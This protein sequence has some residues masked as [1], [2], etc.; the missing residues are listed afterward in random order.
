[1]PLIVFEGIDGSGKTHQAKRL[2]ETLLKQ[3]L[4]VKRMV[5]PS[6]SPIG[7]LIRDIFEG[8]TFK[9]L[10]GW[11]TMA[12][13]FS[14]DRDQ[15]APMLNQLLD[16][17]VFVILDR[18]W[19]SGLA[20]QLAQALQTD[21][22][23]GPAAAAMSEYHKHLRAPDVTF[24]LDVTVAEALRRKGKGDRFEKVQT[25]SLVREYY[26]RCGLAIRPSGQTLAG[27]V[28][29]IDTERSP[30]VDTAERIRVTTENLFGC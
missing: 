17:G 14:A 2:E 30:A 13:L 18:Y 25:L 29:Y 23:D 28:V 20:Y 5:Y 15:Q 16:D 21:G 19:M 1:M 7:V 10:P 27:H 3:G 11:R 24:I 4:Q 6:S 9:E 22:E 12:H 26:R 8:R